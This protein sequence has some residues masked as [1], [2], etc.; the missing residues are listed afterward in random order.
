MC[1]K[2]SLSF[3]G[4]P[5]CSAAGKSECDDKIYFLSISLDKCPLRTKERKKKLCDEVIQREP[6]GMPRRRRTRCY[7]AM[8]SSVFVL[9]PGAAGEAP[10][11]TSGMSRR[12]FSLSRVLAKTNQSQHSDDVD[13]VRR[14][15]ALYRSTGRLCQSVSETCLCGVS[16]LRLCFI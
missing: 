12:R 8:K 3:H 1:L 6:V 5:S 10:E 13:D 16:T 2:C 14:A 7:D 11:E 4:V 9:Q 15:G